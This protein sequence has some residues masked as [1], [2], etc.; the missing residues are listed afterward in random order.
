MGVSGVFISGRQHGNR[1]DFATHEKY[2]AT[3]VFPPLLDGHNGPLR[4]PPPR[5]STG[6][7]NGR[8]RAR[9]ELP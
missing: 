6:G 4:P 5:L 8:Y 7:H 2:E 3:F 1:G 9:K